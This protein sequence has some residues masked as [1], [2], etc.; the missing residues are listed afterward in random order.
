[1]AIVAMG[2]NVDPDRHLLEAVEA[3][4]AVGQV[5]EIST[6]YENPAV[7]RPGQSDFVNAAVWLDTRFLPRDLCQRLRTLEIRLGRTASMDKCSRRTIDL[8]LCLWGSRV[9]ENPDHPIPDPDLLT[10]GYLAAIVS[11]LIPN[12]QHP[13]T[14]EPM[15]QSA[16]RLAPSTTLTPRMSLTS[17]MRR[18][19]LRSGRKVNV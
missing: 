5:R 11:E 2:S 10:R 7:D 16:S 15:A 8:D 4:A 18:A 17:S 9:D 12:F 6:A 19:A 14:G 13:I 3:L 1:M